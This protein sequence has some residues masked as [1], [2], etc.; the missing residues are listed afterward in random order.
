MT[1]DRRNGNVVMMADV[2]VLKSQQI[3]TNRRLDGMDRRFDDIDDK[4]DDVMKAVNE[5]R[6]KDKQ[7]FAFWGK[8]A[9]MSSIL[10]AISIW[11]EKHI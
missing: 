10:G 1:D 4:L 2:A 6:G 8:V 7:D 5:N 3:E 9:G 11:I